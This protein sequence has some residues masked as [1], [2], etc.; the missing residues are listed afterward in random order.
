MGSDGSI[1][2]ALGVHADLSS[3]RSTDPTVGSATDHDAKDDYPIRLL[4]TV[5][6]AVIVFS[7]SMT[8]VSASLPNMADDLDTTE[9]FLAWSVTGLFLVM[10]VGTPVLGRLGDVIGHRRVFI[11]GAIVLS[12]G[13]VLCGIA[14]NALSFVIARMVTGAGIA[15]TLPTGTALIMHAYSL[16]ERS[17]AMGWFQMAMT[18][19]PVLG[20]VIGGPLIELYGWRT[21]FAILTPIS[22]IGVALSLRVIRPTPAI[23]SRTIDWWGAASLG[24]ATFS[25]LMFLERGSSAGFT[26]PITLGLILLSAVALRWFVWVERR[27]GDPMLKLDYL[28]RRNF[29][30]PLIAQPLS[31]FAYMGSFLIAPLLLDGRFGYSVNVIALI[32]LCR[33]A[34]YSI[35]SPVGGRLATRIGERPMIITGSVLIVASMLMWIPGTMWE[36]VPFIIVALALSGLAMG[37]ASPSYSTVL[38]GSVD[39]G[40]LGV[41]NGMGATTMNIGMLTGIQSMFV[42]LG[43]GRDP[44]DFARTFAFGA[45]VAAFG[46]VGALMIRAQPTTA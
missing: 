43:D 23:G 2:P 1:E 24:V 31:Q 10:A 29:T 35:S 22:F 3:D 5:I 44:S 26:D 7:S 12:V 17:R 30:G 18:G 36:S 8:I 42:I 40:D 11:A 4:R 13:T 34:L 16:D 28:R 46:M 33:P 45:I 41:A 20:L 27:V 21:I 39:D 14:P 38:A 15:A 37:L 6:A 25:F 32:L 19:A 9:S